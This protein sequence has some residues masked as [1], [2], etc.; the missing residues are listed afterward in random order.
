VSETPLAGRT[1]LVTGA[2]RGI[3]LAT[4]RSLG[5]NG[6]RVALVARSADALREHA[7]SIGNGA[8]PMQCD[9]LDGEQLARTI[10]RTM[11]AF[12]GAPDILVLNAGVFSLGRI[13]EL[14]PVE[15]AHTLALNVGA[16]YILLHAF[17]PL[18]RARGDGHVVTIGSIADRSA[19][20]E[21]SAYAPAKFAARALH[22][23]LR[24]ELAGSGVRSSLVSP[25]P[26]DTHLW[27]AIDP[28]NR[29]G[30]T[31]RARMLQADAVGD[32][33]LWVVTRG[34]DVNID[35]LRLTRA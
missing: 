2:S 9:L 22:E 16:P 17:V 25:G 29:P 35:E 34:R 4:A 11:Q 21:N 6:A 20:P 26:V 27:N 8:L 1:A 24:L 32:S 14:P 10:D 5:S 15:F 30:F 19:Y 13:G 23:V 7:Q 31:P 33:V 18:M 3:G 12:G 28:D